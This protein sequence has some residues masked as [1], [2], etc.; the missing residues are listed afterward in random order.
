VG[1]LDGSESVRDA[2]TAP[3]GAPEALGEALA[4]RLRAAGA[5]RILAALRGGAGPVPGSAR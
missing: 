1:S 2:M 4:E 3:A 5:G